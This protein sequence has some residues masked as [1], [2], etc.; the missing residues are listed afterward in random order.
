MESLLSTT[1][2]NNIDIYIVSTE[3]CEIMGNFMNMMRFIHIYHP[4]KW[5]SRGSTN[6][7]HHTLLR[8]DKISLGMRYKIDK[9]TP[10]DELSYNVYCAIWV[11][12]VWKWK[13]C[14]HCFNVALLTS[15]FVESLAVFEKRQICQSCN[16]RFI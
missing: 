16:N 8:P 7:R 3:D 12:P 10:F 6:G 14:M 2:A 11:A 1:V 4:D 13:F 5:Q 15:H 9:S